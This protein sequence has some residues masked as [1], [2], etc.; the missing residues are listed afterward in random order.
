MGFWGG[1]W[2]VVK[3]GGRVVVVGT[4]GAV[5]VSTGGLAAPIIG[6]GVY[7]GGKAVKKVGEKCDCKFIEE[8]GDFVEDVGLDGLT[9]GIFNLGTQTAGKLAARE[10]ARHGRRM[11]NGAKLLI[12][13]GQTIKIGSK[14]YKVCNNNLEEIEFITKAREEAMT[15][16]VPSA[17]KL[18][19]KFLW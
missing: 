6:V 17:K 18:S 19:K 11:T 4:A 16:I 14:V 5:I 8:V 12:K 9:G 2:E 3:F 1:V 7:A 10:I 13:I 15:V